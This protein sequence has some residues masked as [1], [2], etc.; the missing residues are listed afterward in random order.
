M[1]VGQWIAEH[2][3]I[4]STDVFS[5]T[6]FARPWVA[7]EWPADLIFA[8][9]Y[10]L[11]GYA[12]LASVVAAAVMALHS[13]LYL[14]LRRRVGAI[15]LT[16]TFVTMDLVIT[17]FMLARPHVM[18]WPVMAAWTVLLARATETGRPPPL[19]SAL[20]LVLWANLHG[21]FPLAAI[22]GGFLALDALIKAEWKT[23]R[24]WLIFAGTCLIAICLQLNGVAGILQPFRVA[25]L[26]TLHLINEWLPSSWGNS[27]VFFGA[28]LLVIGLLLWRGARIP[29]GRLL[30]LLVMLGMAFAQMRHQSWLAI[31]AAVLVPPLPAGRKALQGSKLWPFAV[32]TVPLLLA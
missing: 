23:L 4:P 21:S 19:W 6:A 13:I 24:E 29:I 12:G 5:Y 14:H 28:L 9:A 7:M 10:R 32:A 30:L 15:G 17:E 22:I 31:I 20:L 26:K 27:P 16:V 18:V 11:A 3:R 1:A 2:G 25:N 8:G